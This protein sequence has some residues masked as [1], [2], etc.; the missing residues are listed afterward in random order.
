MR[1]STTKTTLICSE[2]NT[3]FE[4]QRKSTKLKKIG[5]IKN[6]YCYKCKKITQF[7]ELG[8]KAEYL[9]LEEKF[10]YNY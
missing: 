8:P 2:C 10:C 5:H 6:L 4:I 9:E 1:T 7:I 3:P